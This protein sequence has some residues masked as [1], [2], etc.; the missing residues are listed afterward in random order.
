MRWPRPFKRECAVPESWLWRRAPAELLE[1]HADLVGKIKRLVGFPDSHWRRLVAPVLEGYADW[2]QA[3]PASEAHHHAGPGGL[4]RHGLECVHGAL[5]ERAGRILPMDVPPE[6]VAER[7]DRWTFAIILAAL[8]HD[9]AKPLTDVRVSMFDGNQEEIG[10]WNAWLSPLPSQCVWYSVRYRRSRDY[11]LHQSAAFL[12]ATRLIPEEALAWLA[13]DRVAL[14]SWIDAMSGAADASNPIAAIAE[15]ADRQSVAADLAGGFAAMPGS[16]AR[17]LSERLVTGLRHLIDTEALRLNA[18]GA[19][20]WVADGAV[21]LVVKTA[22]DRLRE[23]LRAEGHAGVP[24]DNNRL[25][26]ELQQW[27]VIEPNQ[28]KAVWSGMITLPGGWTAGPLTMLRVPI[29]PIWGTET[30]PEDIGAAISVGEAPPNP[31][32]V[33]VIK[34][35]RALSAAEESPAPSPAV[36]SIPGPCLAPSLPPRQADIEATDDGVP[37]ESVASSVS[38]ADAFLDWLKAGLRDGALEMNIAGARIHGVPGG[39]LLVSPRIF[40][41]FEAAT[42]SSWLATQ[43]AFLRQKPRVHTKAQDGTNIWSFRVVGE[44][45]RG[46]QLKGLLIENPGGHGLPSLPPNPHLEQK[47]GAEQNGAE[48]AIGTIQGRE[49]TEHGDTGSSDTGVEIT[50]AGRSG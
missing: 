10:E 29:V 20:G 42:G 40:R 22:L 41:D 45:R 12:Q 17:P 49:A 28:D 18:P 14:A 19:A 5:R 24:G 16:R 1:E 46:A 38:L 25:M 36:A 33:S 39:V 9:V 30:G 6:E 3:L 31:E 13:S 7:Q 21:W 4:L 8:L 26:D 44:H 47:K 43:K 23:H 50:Q 2:I 37:A 15:A 27:H 35:D 48:G 32:P 11:R 34:P